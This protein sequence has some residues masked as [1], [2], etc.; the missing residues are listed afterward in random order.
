[1]LASASA[2]PTPEEYRTALPFAHCALDGLWDEDE[3]GRVADAVERQ[4]TWDGEKSFFGSVAKRWVS[5]WD[6]LPPEVE[7]F[8]NYA[9][10]PEFIQLLEA[11]TGETGLVPD[12]YLNGGGIHSTGPGGFLKLHAD[13]NWHN[14][15]QLYRRLNMLVYL[16]RGWL[17]EWGGALELAR[18]LEDGSL[19]VE[20]SV[21]PRFN[22]T[23]VFTTDDASYHGQ[24]HPLMAPEGVSRNSIALYYYVSERPEGVGEVKRV[25]TDYRNVEGARLTK[26]GPR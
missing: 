4:E 1:M 10:R 13:F 11:A 26:R 24:P 2:L 16:N 20:K 6:C 7:K 22:T 5:S 12:P 3:L 19:S 15:L 21:L 23:V 17:D 18:K 25:R 9:M 8:I 14:G